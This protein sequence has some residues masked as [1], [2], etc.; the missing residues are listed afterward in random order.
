MHLLLTTALMLSTSLAHSE[1]VVVRRTG[2]APPEVR[3][4]FRGL[5]RIYADTAKALRVLA[6]RPEAPLKKDA[7]TAASA[8]HELSAAYTQVTGDKAGGQHISEAVAEILRPDSSGGEGAL[9]QKYISNLYDLKS[10]EQS[11]VLRLALLIRQEALKASGPKGAFPPNSLLSTPGGEVPFLDVSLAP[12]VAGGQSQS[13]ALDALIAVARENEIAGG[14][15]VVGDAHLWMRRFG[16]DFFADFSADAGTGLMRLRYDL[17]GGATSAQARWYFLTKA[18]LEAGF[19]VG[20]QSGELTAKLGGDATE[21]SVVEKIDRVVIA[22]RALEAAHAL[23]NAIGPYLA[24]TLSSAENNQRIDALASAFVAE[25]RV[26]MV[27]TGSE[28][29]AKGMLAYLGKSAARETLR[30]RMDKTLRALALRGFPSGVPVGQ[31]TVNLY[32]NTPLEAA[33]SSGALRRDASGFVRRRSRRPSPAGRA[34]G[35]AYARGTVSGEIT[36]DKGKASRGGVIFISPYVGA[37]EQKAVAGATGLVTTQGGWMARILAARAGIPAINFPQGRW[38]DGAGLSLEM[39]LYNGKGRFIGWGETL[40]REGD[41]IR[42]EK[43]ALHL[44]PQQSPTQSLK[45]P[46]TA[47]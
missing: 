16:A 46:T 3:E 10:K 33:L 11:S 36:Y 35:T 40:L 47:P 18:L 28:R 20:V 31:R 32:Y 12:L 5:G 19:T 39:P 1:G 13:P 4:W 44:I 7:R 43:D 9:H 38:N 23:E 21:L 24:G 17:P 8:L 34:V 25:G 6:Q 42:I 27:G 2:D 30:G 37:K 45:L 41:R 29:V 14:S 26:P 22:W 15:F